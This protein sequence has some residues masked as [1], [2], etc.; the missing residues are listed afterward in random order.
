M[1]NYVTVY[2]DVEVDVDV[3]TVVSEADDQTL[4]DTLSARGYTCVK[5]SAADSDIDNED[6]DF[7]IKLLDNTAETWYTRRVRDKLIQ[8]RYN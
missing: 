5:N 1:G 4:V 3:D 8:A 7:L 2:A 6:W